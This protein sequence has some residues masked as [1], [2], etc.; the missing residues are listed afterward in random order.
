MAG[1]DQ[2]NS[3][4][5]SLAMRKKAALH[6]LGERYA[7]Q[8]EAHA[9]EAAPWQDRTSH[10]RQSLFGNVFERNQNIITR[11]GH[12]ASYGVYLELANQGKYA[13]LLPTVRRFVKD[14]L[15]DAK[16]VMTG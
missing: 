7:A 16:K 9:K 14:F 8:L 10:A 12:G 6:A 5:L 1:A 2:V 13:I 11:L 15:E 3:N 4:L